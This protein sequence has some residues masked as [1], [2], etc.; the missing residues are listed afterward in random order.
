MI[1]DIF[2]L[3]A[4]DYI[5]D[6]ILD[7]TVGNISQNEMAEDIYVAWLLS[8]M[9]ER[10]KIVDYVTNADWDSIGEWLRKMSNSEE[11]NRLRILA[12]N[13]SKRRKI[14]TKRSCYIVY[15]GENRLDRLSARLALELLIDNIT[16][17]IGIEVRSS[18]LVNRCFIVSNRSLSTASTLVQHDFWLTIPRPHM[19]RLIV[20]ESINVNSFLMLLR[21][22][23]PKLAERLR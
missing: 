23:I 11:A 21:P 1:A 19:I 15:S 8:N 22:I 16:I 2:G 7:A 4:P 13:K 17:A 20:R 14:L 12:V 18:N 9:N 10:R 5:L 3:E 6:A